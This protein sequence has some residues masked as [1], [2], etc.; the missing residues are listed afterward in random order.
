MKFF[1]ELTDKSGNRIFINPERVE[2]IV[3]Q[4]DG[5]W[6]IFMIGRD[7]SETINQ[8]GDIMPLTDYLRQDAISYTIPM[9]ALLGS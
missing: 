9:G 8:D 7:M 2:C 5:S 4:P 3:R 6:K 1:V